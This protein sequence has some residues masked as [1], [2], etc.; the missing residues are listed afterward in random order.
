[1]RVFFQEIKKFSTH[2]GTWC[3]SLTPENKVRSVQSALITAGYTCGGPAMWVR[4]TLASRSCWC[5]LVFTVSLRERVC[6]H[7]GAPPVVT[8]WRMR[9][10]Q[11]LLEC[12][13]EVNWEKCVTAQLQF[14]ED[15]IRRAASWN[16]QIWNL[17]MLIKN[18]QQY[19]ARNISLPKKNHH[20][21]FV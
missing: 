20:L 4:L 15:N 8:F 13:F 2:Q 5:L 6:K 1:M 21:H 3:L 11:F 14:C 12:Y 19:N 18:N 7:F 16:R 10:Q 17:W 9:Y